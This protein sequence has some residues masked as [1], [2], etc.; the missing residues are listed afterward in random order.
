MPGEAKINILLV[1]DNLDQQALIEEAISEQEWMELAM[2]G[3]LSGALEHSVEN[4]VDIVLLDL[5]LPD[6]EGKETL[7]RF[8]EAFPELPV[9]V[10]TA[11]KNPTLERSLILE[12]ADDYLVK[13][14]FDYDEL[15]RY[16]EHALDRSKNYQDLKRS[17][18]S[19]RT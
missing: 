1:E 14:R 11:T 7:V 18:L 3:D 5:T 19:C 16:I 6:S 4:T 2:F 12:G 9:I 10:V 8:R 17:T 15:W 13:G